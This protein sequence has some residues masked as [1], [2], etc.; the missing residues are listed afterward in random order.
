[1]G[2]TSTSSPA[3]LPT[4]QHPA[5]SIADRSSARATRTSIRFSSDDG[6][7]GGDE[8]RGHRWAT[9]SSG[10][11]AD[12]SSRSRLRPERF[13]AVILGVHRRPEQHHGLLRVPGRSTTSSASCSYGFLQPDQLP[14]ARV[15][16]PALIA[17]LAP[18][19]STTKAGQR[20]VTSSWTNGNVFD[21][22]MTTALDAQRESDYPGLR[23]VLVRPRDTDESEGGPI[24]AALTADS[25]HPGGVNILMGDGSVRFVK[26][27]D[28]RPSL[29]CPGHNRRRRGDLGRRVLTRLF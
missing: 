11:K 24:Y 15:N 26:D 6:Y 22:G 18:T 7:Q 1:M 25:Y 5:T 9:G 20:S 12:P 23:A 21:S 3:N 4:S 19:C 17:A 27:S 28:Q 29:A 8:L 16:S 13:E 14:L 2:L 10:G